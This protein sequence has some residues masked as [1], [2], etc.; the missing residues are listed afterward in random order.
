M[1]SGERL[2]REHEAGGQSHEEFPTASGSVPVSGFDSTGVCVRRTVS[3]GDPSSPKG[4]EARSESDPM[5]ASQTLPIQPRAAQPPPQQP[6]QHPGTS[7]LQPPNLPLSQ[8]VPVAQAVPVAKVVPVSQGAAVSQGVPV[9]Q[10]LPVSQ[11]VPVSQT[12][13]VPSVPRG[14][15]EPFPV[16]W[17]TRTPLPPEQGGPNWAAMGW[18]T[19]DAEGELSSAPPASRAAAP[20]PVS[21]APASAP[22]SSSTTV[23]VAPDSVATNPGNPYEPPAGST[24]SLPTAPPRRARLPWSRAHEAAARLAE[25]QASSRVAQPSPVSRAALPTPPR[26]AAAVPASVS[27][28]PWGPR[29]LRSTAMVF[30]ATSLG[31]L[32]AAVALSP[33]NVSARAAGTLR[34]PNG[35]RPVSTLIAGS[36]TDVFVRPGELVQ[37]GQALARLEAAELGAGLV[38]RERELMMLEQDTLEAEAA[39]REFM[40]RAK[41]AL[42]E[43]RSALVRRIDL[44]TS[45]ARA[46][47]SPLAVCATP[48]EGPRP[49]H[50]ETI[51]ALRAELALVDLELA[52]RGQSFQQRERERREALSRAEAGVADVED[53]LDSVVLRSQVAG[54]VESLSVSPGDMVA[55]GA[56][57]AQVVPTDAPRTVAVYLPLSELSLVAPEDDATLELS[58]LPDNDAAVLPARVSYVVPELAAPEELERELGQQPSGAFVRIELELLGDQAQLRLS[59]HLRSGARIVARFPARERQIARVVVDKALA[60]FD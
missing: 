50:A 18:A 47:A 44:A 35:V 31:V 52:D 57:L 3:V 13:P 34:L 24:R 27:A 51:A 1:V 30:G 6:A 11:G 43:R 33:I 25:S 56:V 26:S 16:L 7:A 40:Q 41:N 9:S 22:V 21:S 36:I 42:Y 17:S 59:Q 39:E 55:A 15:R 28:H 48:E 5:K 2:R 8:R 37:A 23:F 4:D 46:C 45:N 14:P 60:L 12:V 49:D 53:L 19:P 32:C 20:A 38:K 54:R 58:A 10:R 29:W